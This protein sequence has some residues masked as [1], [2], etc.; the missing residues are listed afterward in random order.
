MNIQVLKI[1]C[2]ILQLIGL[3]LIVASTFL[4]TD[5]QFIPVII[6]ISGFAV[7]GVINNIMGF[8]LP[9]VIASVPAILVAL[10]VTRYLGLGLSKLIPKEHSEASSSA[11]FSS[12]SR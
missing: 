1:A 6:G 2:S 11:S 4:E 12:A 7:Q 8:Y 5:P 10:P 3:G 9:S